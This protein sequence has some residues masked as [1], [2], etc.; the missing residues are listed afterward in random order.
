MQKGA[1]GYITKTSTRDEM[2]KGIIAVYKGEKYICTEIKNIISNQMFD[3][4][5]H[6][7]SLNSLSIRELEIIDYLKQGLTSREIASTIYISSKT[8]EVH[9]YNIL[10]KLKMK[11][12]TQ[13]INYA[14]QVYS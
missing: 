5:D 9:R 8:V 7:P 14:T 1:S 3:E 12:T 11:N 13:L 2:I 10:R 4:T 6:L